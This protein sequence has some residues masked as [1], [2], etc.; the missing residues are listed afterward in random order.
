MKRWQWMIIGV[1][2]FGAFAALLL[3]FWPKL[4]ESAQ[5]CCARKSSEDALPEELEIPEAA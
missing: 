4:I 3:V 5:R 2:L 1:A